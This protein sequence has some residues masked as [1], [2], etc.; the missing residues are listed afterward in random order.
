MIVEFS[1]FGFLSKNRLRSYPVPRLNY[2]ASEPDDCASISRALYALNAR[3]AHGRPRRRGLSDEDLVAGAVGAAERRPGCQH[4]CGFAGPAAEADVGGGAEAAAGGGGAAA[5]G[6]EAAAG[7]VTQAEPGAAARR[8]S[9]AR[10]RQI[11]CCTAGARIASIRLTSIPASRPNA[12][13]RKCCCSIGVA[14]SDA[15]NAAAARSSPSSRR[16]PLAGCAS[17]S[18]GRRRRS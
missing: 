14:A 1:A 9:A 5:G 3:I 6:D 13:A 4:A 16:G 18:P 8:H 10:P 12:T 7:G 2:H 15:R 11:C 17:S